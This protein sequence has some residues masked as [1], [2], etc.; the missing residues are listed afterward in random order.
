MIA[1]RIGADLAAAVVAAPGYLE[2]I[3][4]P[5]KPSDLDA[6]DCIRFRFPSGV[7]FPWLVEKKGKRIEVAVNGS[8]TVNDE[9]LAVRAAVDGVAFSTP[10][11][12]MS[13]RRSRRDGWFPCWKIGAGPRHRSFSTTR[14]GG[15]CHCRCRPSSSSCGETPNSR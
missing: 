9:A 11:P 6:H 13:R 15:R 4:R 1:V 2:R 5:V 10:P 3:P 8:L 14:A 7:I 12:V